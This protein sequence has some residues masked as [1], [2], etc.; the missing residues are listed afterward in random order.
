MLTSRFMIDAVYAII[1]VTALYT[2]V[3]DVWI[4][5]RRRERTI[6]RETERAKAINWRT[7]LAMITLAW[8]PLVIAIVSGGF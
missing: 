6:D 5:F 7:G 3:H 2:V 4:G 8:L 1:F